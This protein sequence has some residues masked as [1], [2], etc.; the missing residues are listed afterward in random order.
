MFSNNSWPRKPMQGLTKEKFYQM[1]LQM[2]KTH[3]VKSFQKFYYLLTACSEN[4]IFGNK[5]KKLTISNGLVKKGRNK[6]RSYSLI[7]PF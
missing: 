1:P 7:F 3:T 2:K 4:F 6:S 5:F